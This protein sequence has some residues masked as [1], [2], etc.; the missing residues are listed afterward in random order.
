MER[1]RTSIVILDFSIVNVALPSIQSRFH[2]APTTLQWVVSAYALKFGGFLLLMGRGSDLF[3]VG[4]A[5]LAAISTES[6]LVLLMASYYVAAPGLV[7]AVVSLNIAGTTGVKSGRQGLAA[8]L[9][10]TSQQIGAAIGVSVASVIAVTVVLSLGSG[11]AAV[12]AG[13]LTALLAA[14]GL[15]VVAVILALYLVRRNL[16]KE[17][18]RGAS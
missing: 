11:T 17:K 7:S 5:G 8:G 16:L 2:L 14:E 1:S 15:I 9:L 3:G 10:A 12:V 6:S 4:V 18:E 13:Y